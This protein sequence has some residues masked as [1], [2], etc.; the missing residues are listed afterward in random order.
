LGGKGTGGITMCED[1]V[2][3][4]GTRIDRI[5]FH[6]GSRASSHRA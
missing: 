5:F 3:G 2:S 4:A 6:Q 1:D